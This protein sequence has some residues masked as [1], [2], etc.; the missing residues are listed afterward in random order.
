MATPSEPLETTCPSGTIATVSSAEIRAAGRALAECIGDS[1]IAAGFKKDRS[2]GIPVHPDEL[3][4]LRVYAY[5]GI[6]VD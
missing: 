2:T 5:T 1:F 3:I 4:G 6:P